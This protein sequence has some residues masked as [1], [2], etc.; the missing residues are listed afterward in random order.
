MLLVNDT[1]GAVP[2]EKVDSEEEGFGKK[3]KGSVSLDK[4]VDKVRA[5]EPLDFA[6]HIDEVSIG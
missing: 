4:E 5:H 2:I 1:L 6:L 3:R